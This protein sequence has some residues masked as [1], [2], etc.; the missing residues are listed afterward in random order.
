VTDLV[1]VVGSLHS[2]ANWVH[3]FLSAHPEVTGKKD[4]WTLYDERQSVERIREAGAALFDGA[5][6]PLAV[7][8][9]VP[10]V[11]MVDD[12][13]GAWPEARFINVIRDGREAVVRVRMSGPNLDERTASL[14]GTRIHDA[15]ESWA[16]ATEAGLSATDKLGDRMKTIRYEDVVR[17]RARAGHEVLSYLG[18]KTDEGTVYEILE[19]EG[20]RLKSPEPVDS[21]KAYF[22]VYR[23]WKFHRAAWETLRRA[24]Y[25]RDPKWWW[26]PIKR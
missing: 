6:T 11:F 21:W 18:L 20:G 14:F 23:A 15:A 4:L 17:D 1:F 22:S 26:R 3:D 9:S 7:V 10:A 16:R 12:L 2:G 5:S 24:G 19:G 8:R 25:E 13:A